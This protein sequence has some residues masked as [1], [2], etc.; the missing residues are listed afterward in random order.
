MPNY[1]PGTLDDSDALRRKLEEIERTAKEANKPTGSM[2][3]N[4]TGK[5]QEFDGSGMERYAL[6][7]NSCVFMTVKTP[8]HEMGYVGRWELIAQ[9]FL[10]LSDYD[11]L[12]YLYERVS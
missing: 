3:Y 9:T 12:L 1:R 4:T 5:M 7:I 10:P 2:A 8:P 11:Q 6:P